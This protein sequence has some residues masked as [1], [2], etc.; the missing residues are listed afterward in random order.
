MSVKP[1]GLTKDAGF[2]I[3]VRRTLPV[4]Q[5]Q[6][7]SYLISPE[8]LKSWLGDLP[9]LDLAVK[10]SYQT[11][12]GSTGEIRA[13][14]PLQQLRLTWQPKDWDKPSTVQIRLI[15]GKEGRTTVSFH[16]EHLDGPQTRAQ[17]KIRW[18]EVL[19][20]MTEHFQKTN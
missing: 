19:D 4:T 14:K 12:D 17:M 20:K 5:E 3:G 11:A 7:W 13:A 9:R 10:R 8:G 15:P 1:V 16:Q 6:A 18:E 2:Q